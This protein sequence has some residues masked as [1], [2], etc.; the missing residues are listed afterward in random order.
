MCTA[1]HSV[2]QMANTKVQL[3][4]YVIMAMLNCITMVIPLLNNVSF[5][6]SFFPFLFIQF[7][8]KVYQSSAADINGL[9]SKW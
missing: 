1:V 2:E 3:L 6:I 8:S 5:D 7:S 4:N 9:R